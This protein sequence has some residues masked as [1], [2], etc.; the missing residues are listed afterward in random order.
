MPSRC[1]YCHV[2]LTWREY[3]PHIA[4]HLERQADGQ[5]Q[6]HKTLPP[7]DRYQENLANTPQAY[8]CDRCQAVTTM[9]EDIIRTYLVDPWFYDPY[10]FCGGCGRYLHQ[11]HFTWVTT[12]Q[13]LDHYFAGLQAAHPE[14]RPSIFTRRLPP[15]VAIVFGVLVLA[16]VIWMRT[17]G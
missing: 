3:S 7:E 5:Q 15:W 14:R 6:E 16:W 12:G 17:R 4:K 11:R 13:R 10:T 9:P 2:E 8:C 1:P